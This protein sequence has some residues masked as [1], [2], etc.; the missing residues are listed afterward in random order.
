MF[1]FCVDQV[2]APARLRARHGVLK[3]EALAVAC[4][5]Q[6]AAALMLDEARAQA[7]ALLAEANARAHDTVRREQQRVAHEAT[8]ILHSLRSAQERLLDAL[9]PLVTDL[10]GRAFER[11]VLE[12]TPQERIAAAV[13]RVRE[14]A[15]QR[16][17]AALAWVHPDDLALSAGA[18]WEVRAD[19]RLARGTCKLEA[20]SGEWL[21][22]FE[23]G[24]TALADALRAHALP[25]A[26]TLADR[27]LQSNS[28]DVDES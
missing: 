13:R 27:P 7:E 24:A 10:A 1:K 8:A 23:L 25:L 12:A 20:S 4:D 22:G 2:S 19:A 14:E 3:C 11:L 17:V 15:P 5:G 6:R 28:S 16:L 21:A 9:M 26:P 18:P